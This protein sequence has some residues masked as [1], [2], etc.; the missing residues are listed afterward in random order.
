LSYHAIG[1]PQLMQAE[2]GWATESRS[3]TRLATTER[4]LPTASPGTNASVARAASIPI[5]IGTRER[6]LEERVR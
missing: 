4:K 6:A 5:V 3:G 1:V 2:P